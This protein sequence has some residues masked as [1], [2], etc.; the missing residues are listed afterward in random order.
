M[1]LEIPFNKNIYNR[2]NQLNFNSVWKKNLKNNNRRIIWG[3]LG[4]LL[5]GFMV[6]DENYVGFLFIGLGI[7][8]FANFIDYR[9]YYRKSKKRYFELINAE[10]NGYENS[11]SRII[12]EFEN[13]YFSYSD[14]R[15][16]AKIKWS[17]FKS[18]RIIE[19][20]LFLDMDPKNGLSYILSKSELKENEWNYILELLKEKM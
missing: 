2:Q 3:V 12:W 20:T 13:D 6:Y 5:G 10:I 14:H 4:L 17:T 9:Q 7:H 19:N 8:Y 1:K 18:Y 15:F 16:E 11:G